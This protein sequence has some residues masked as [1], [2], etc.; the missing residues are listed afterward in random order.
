[1]LITVLR[2][3]SVRGRLLGT[4]L[5]NLAVAEL[6]RGM[7]VTRDIET[8]SRVGSQNFGPLGCHLYY[9]GLGMSI[10]VSN[11]AIAI[12]CLDATLNLSQSLKTQV[13]AAVCSWV[14]AIIFTAIMFYGLARGPEVYHNSDHDICALVMGP[15]MVARAAESAYLPFHSDYFCTGYFD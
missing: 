3:K 12:S 10:C 8:E 9:I 5:I 15:P 2:T 13:L 6:T 4:M 7:V 1:M 14:L 11:A